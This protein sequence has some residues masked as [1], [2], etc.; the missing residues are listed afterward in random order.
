MRRVADIIARDPETDVRDALRIEAPAWSRIDSIVTVALLIAA[1]ATRFFNLGK[2]TA[3]VFDEV[4]PLGVAHN[5]L[6]HQPFRNTHPPLPG[7]VIALSIKLF[8]DNPW[9]WRVANASIGTALV[10]I[11]YLLG[12]RMFNSRLA[13]AMAAGFVLCDGLFMVDSRLALWEIFYLTSAAVAYLMLFRFAQG[14]DP[15]SRRRSLMWMGV[16]LGLGLGS[17]LGIPMVTMVLTIGAALLVVVGSAGGGDAAANDRRAIPYREMSS[18]LALVGGLSGLLYLAVFWPNYWFGWWRGIGDQIVYYQ[19]EFR[20]QVTAFHGNPHHY[21]SRWWSWPLMLR[22]MRYYVPDEFVVSPTGAFPSIRAIG[23][24]VLWWGALMAMVLTARRTITRRSAA[25]AFLVAGY[26]LYMVMW[27]PIG[28]FQFI[29]YY[30]PALYLGF[31]ALAAM[32]AECWEGATRKWEQ[33]ALLIAASPALILG[34]GAIIGAGAIAAIAI[35][36]AALLRTRERD[37]GKMVCALY[38]AGALILFVYF[39]PLW[40]GLPLTPQQLAGRMWF[41]GPGLP[42]W[43]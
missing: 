40:V 16:A 9:S 23:T 12:R 10:A 34:L 31:L 15:F 26:L 38:L 1:A 35:A 8:G 25:R 18:I 39:L 33:G 42:N 22:P 32:L 17:K 24:P 28:R 20:F 6:Q 3:V 19:A 2:P 11:T 21:A 37:T 7:E 27:I 4:F 13:G 5:L 29:Y 41:R 30:M 36:Y 43:L 14:T